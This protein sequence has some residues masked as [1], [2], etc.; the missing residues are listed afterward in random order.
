MRRISPEFQQQY[1]EIPYGKIIGMRNKLV[2]DYNEINI[3]LVWSVIQ[4]NIPELIAD[5]KTIIPL[6]NPEISGENQ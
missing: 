6:Q 1:P 3:K 4:T 2:H 5:L